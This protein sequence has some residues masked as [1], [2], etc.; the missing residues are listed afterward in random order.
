MSLQFTKALSIVGLAIVMGLFAAV[1]LLAGIVIFQSLI[2]EGPIASETGFGGIFGRIATLAAA[3]L[4]LVGFL[5]CMGRLRTGSWSLGWRRL[6]WT[7]LWI[8]VLV[9]VRLVVGIM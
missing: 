7:A 2:G 5:L 6:L 8:G 3:V 1:A 4:V 9:L